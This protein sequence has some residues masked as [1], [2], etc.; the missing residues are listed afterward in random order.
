MNGNLEEWSLQALHLFRTREHL[1]GR[2]TSRGTV[3]RVCSLRASGYN[4]KQKQCA[5]FTVDVVVLTETE[6]P[7]YNFSFTLSGN[8][9]A[10]PTKR[11]CQIGYLVFLRRMGSQVVF[12]MYWRSPFHHL[13]NQ[14]GRTN[15]PPMACPDLSSS[16]GGL[17]I[18]RDQVLQNRHFSISHCL[19]QPQLS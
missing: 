5:S 18:R 4:E 15:G 17:G 7:E 8:N 1:S 14:R 3:G 19:H 12:P 16:D 2:P 9:F 13:N 6:G 11:Q 10:S